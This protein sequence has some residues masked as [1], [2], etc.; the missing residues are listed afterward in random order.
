MIATLAVSYLTFMAGLLLGGWCKASKIEQAKDEG[1][2]EATERLVAQRQA[3][4]MVVR[5]CGEARLQVL[6]R[7]TTTVSP[8]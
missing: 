2:I 1:R 4:T 7:Y 6:A 8:N 5:P 3:E